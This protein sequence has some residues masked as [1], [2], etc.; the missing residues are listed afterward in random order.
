MTDQ[1]NPEDFIITR[2]RKKYKFAKFANA[3]NCFEFDQWSQRAVDVI[4]V[5][6]GT[7]LFSLELAKANPDKVYAAIDLKADRLQTGAY[8]AIDE[9]VTNIY[10]IRARA[11]QLA[12]MFAANSL[13]EIWL[14]FAD[15]FPKRRSAGRRMSHPTFLKIYRQLLKSG[16]QFKLKHDNPMFFNW[17]LEQLVASGWQIEQLSFDLHDSDMPASA[18]IMTT[19]EQRWIGEG[20]ISQYVAASYKNN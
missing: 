7:G 6:A 18:K 14:T 3:D 16:G 8:Q 13:T 19:Y 1:L 11:D 2:K 17:S 10:F 9:G 20:R 4:E 15:P 12:E 5:G